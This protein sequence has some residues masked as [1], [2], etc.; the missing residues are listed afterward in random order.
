MVEKGKKKLEQKEKNF[1][2][3]VL[4]ALDPD[5]QSD[6]INSA[7]PREVAEFLTR[8]NNPSV[9]LGDFLYR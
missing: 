5:D 6:D 8:S 9:T 4:G 1:A 7:T 2:L 3:T